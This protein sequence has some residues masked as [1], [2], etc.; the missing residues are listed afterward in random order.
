[1]FVGLKSVIY[2]SSNLDQDKKFWE[3]VTGTKPYMDKPYYVGF[4]ISGHDLG[5][6]PN[7][8]KEGLT[9][10]VAY[11][12]V[13]NAKEVA[14]QLLANGATVKGELRDVGDGMMMGTFKDPSGNIFGI[15]DNPENKSK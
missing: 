4:S 10:P 14:A 2:P 9:I 3:S 8:A 12:N 11:W 6:D 5:L 7:A 13:K 15:I 1:M